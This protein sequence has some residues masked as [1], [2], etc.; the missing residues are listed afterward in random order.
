MM[1][2]LNNDSSD[3]KNVLF[4]QTKSSI[5]PLGPANEFS[6]FKDLINEN[7]GMREWSLGKASSVL[8]AGRVD[9][10]GGSREDYRHLMTEIR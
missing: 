7:E 4:W 5:Q 10:E 1:D 3:G 2:R 9:V 6:K 8:R